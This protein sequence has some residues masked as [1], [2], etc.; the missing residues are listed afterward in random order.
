MKIRVD[1]VP[2]EYRAEAILDGLRREDLKGKKILIPRAR[3]ARDILP[4]ELR[5]AGADVDVVEVY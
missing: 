5:K 1:W 2:K 3:M 4:D